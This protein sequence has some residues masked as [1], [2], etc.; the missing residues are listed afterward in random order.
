MA[1]Y[2]RVP[3]FVPVLI[4]TRK[5]RLNT[6][7]MR[8]TTHKIASLTDQFIVLKRVVF[9]CYLF[10]NTCRWFFLQKKERKKEID[11]LVFYT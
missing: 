10:S 9:L 6:K 11:G 1:R 5:Q 8:L 2:Y 4:S 7:R 3:S